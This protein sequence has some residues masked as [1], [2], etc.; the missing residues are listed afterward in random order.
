MQFTFAECN[1]CDFSYGSLSNSNLTKTSFTACTFIGT[2]LSDTNATEAVFNGCKLKNVDFSDTRFV[3]ARFLGKSKDDPM[4]LVNCD[5]S[6]CKFEEVTF[7]YV[8]FINCVF[9]GSVMLKCKKTDDQLITKQ[10]AGNLFGSGSS[11]ITYHNT[12][13]LVS[14]KNK[15]VE[16][17]K[18]I[19]RNKP[20]SR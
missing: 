14:E 19:Y 20:C 10:T 2:D 17:G 9:T 5:F 3:K 1:A 7:K 6:D 15:K 4:I 8:R 16:K 12:F 11:S 18:C 13:L